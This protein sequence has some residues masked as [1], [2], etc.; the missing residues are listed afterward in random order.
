M[1]PK[2]IALVATMLLTSISALLLVGGVSAG[3]PTLQTSGPLPSPAEMVTFLTNQERASAG[4]PPLKA[5][6]LLDQAATSHSLAMAVA[7]FF[8]HINPF[9]GTDPGDR[10]LEAGY[11]FSGVAENIAEGPGTADEVVQGWMNSPGHRANILDPSYREIGTGYVFDGA[12]TVPCGD[13]PC[14]HYWTQ[15]FGVQADVYPLI[16]SGEAISTTT[17][18]VKIY[19]H[20]QEWATEMR[21]RNDQ[22]EFTA[23][24]PFVAQREW[25]LPTEPGFH[26]VTTEI[27]AG[28]RIA[29]AS[30]AI[31]YVAS[32]GAPQPEVPAPPPPTPTPQPGVPGALA[33]DAK[34]DPTPVVPGQE[35]IVTI[36]LR[37][38]DLPECAGIPGWP[39]DAILYVDNSASAGS[40]AGSKLEQAKS[41]ALVLVDQMA[42]PVYADSE[43]A[44]ALSRFGMVSAS[45]V[46][47]GVMT[48]ISE[49]SEDFP[50]A[51]TA[52]GSISSGADVA[53][54]E[55]IQL[56]I[57]EMQAKARPNGRQMMLTV[58][59]DDVPFTEDATQA[60]AQAQAAGIELYVIALGDKA[61]ISPN[62]EAE[63][64]AGHDHVYYNPTAEDIRRL[65]IGATGGSVAL[66]AKSIK[67]VADASSSN[68]VTIVSWGQ[69]GALEDGNPTWRL[70][71][72]G[73]GDTADLT[74]TIGIKPAAVTGAVSIATQMRY[75]DCS[76]YLRI[77][78]G[79]I[80]RTGIESPPVQPTDTPTPPPG[81]VPAPAPTRDLAALCP[82]SNSVDVVF[83]M[84]TSGS[85][86]DE[87]SEL[88]GQIDTIVSSLREMGIVVN[89]RIL[90]I[91][92][93]RDCTADTVANLVPGRVDN[94][95]DWGP[96]VADLAEGYPWKTGYTRLIV[97]MSD[98]GPE[99]GDSV[100]D[101][102]NDRRA[103]D[104][105]IAAAQANNTLVSP[106][107]GT[108]YNSA[109]E[110][111]ARDLAHSTNGE[112]F[113]S[114]DPPSD[115]ADGLARLLAEAACSP[116][117]DIV[118][119]ECPIA[120]D[121]VITIAGTNFMEGI[122]V[123]IAGQPARNVVRVNGTELQALIPAGLP[124]GRYDITVINPPGGW[125]YTKKEAIIVGPCD[126]PPPVP[127]EPP[128]A[129]A[130]FTVTP[131]PVTPTPEPLLA[132]PRSPLGCGTWYW[133][134]LPWL[135]P[136]LALLLWWLIM[137]PSWHRMRE[138]CEQKAWRCRIPCLLLFLYTLWLAYLIG[139]ALGAGLCVPDEAVYFWRQGGGL[140]SLGD[141]GIYVTS[142]DNEG[143][144]QPFTAANRHGCVGCHAVSSSGGMLASTGEPVPGPLRVTTLAGEDVPIPQIDALYVNWSP[145]GH[146]LAYASPEG[147]I[148]ILDLEAGTTVPLAGAS[149]HG[150]FETMPAWSHDG[151]RIAFVRTTSALYGLMIDAP[152]DIYTVPSEGGQAQPLAGASGGG[153]SYYPAF[154]PDGQWLAYT[155]HTTG[156]NSY[157]DPAAEIFVVPAGGGQSQ[158]IAANDAADGT[159]LANVSNS[160]PTWS[161][162]GS[163][164]AFSSKRN[165]ENY[166]IMLAAID[167]QGMSGPA[168]PLPGAAQPGVFEHVPFWGKPPQ[169]VPWWQRLLDLWPWLIPLLILGLL[170][171]LLCR[172]RVTVIVEPP[173]PPPP[174]P[175]RK[176]WAP[177]PPVGQWIGPPP[178]WNPEPT[179]VIG[180][181]GTGRWILTL[182]KKNLLDAGAGNITEDVRLLLLDTG[183]G[184]LMDGQ[185][186]PVSFAGV[187]LSPDETIVLGEDL[188]DLVRAIAEDEE[189]RVETEM[190]GWFPAKTYARRLSAAELDL[191]EGTHHRRPMG[192]AAI[193]RQARRGRNGELWQRLLESAAAVQEEDH[194]RIMI[195]GSLSGG[196][197][198]AAVFDAAYL[199]RHAGWTVGAKATTVEGFLA[200]QHTFDRVAT[201]RRGLAINT[202]AAMRDMMRFQLVQDRGYPMRY[203]RTEAGD[204]V[205]DGRVVSR[206]LDDCLLFDAQRPLRPLTMETP[207]DGVLASMADAITLHLDRA[208]RVGIDSVL[209]YRRTARQLTDGEQRR[210]AETV[211]SSLGTFA[212]RLPIYD[213]I[214]ALKARWAKHLLH[215]FL[216]GETGGEVRFDPALN[217]EDPAARMEEL[218][219][220]FLR[221]VAGLGTIPRVPRF[222]FSLL[223]EEGGWSAARAPELQA[224]T[225]GSADQE[226]RSYRS[227]LLEGVTKLLN[228]SAEVELLHAR[229]G[230]IGYVLH[231]L[232]RVERM[233][234][235]VEGEV[236]MLRAKVGEDLTPILA[237][238]DPLAESYRSATADLRRSLQAQAEALTD[239]AGGSIVETARG[240]DDDAEGAYEQL[241]A[242]EKELNRRREQMCAIKVRGYFLSGELLKEWYSKYLAQTVQ[243]HLERFYWRPAPDGRGVDL[244]FAGVGDQPVRLGGGGATG[245]AA[246]LLDLGDYLARPI[247]NAE[248]LADYL[249]EEELKA[250]QLPATAQKLWEW[251]SPL[252]DF[253]RSAAPETQSR[254]VLGANKTVQQAQ[255]LANEVARNLPSARQMLNLGLTDPYTLLLAQMVD[256]IPVGATVPYRDAESYY[257]AAH[258]LTPETVGRGMGAE[259]DAVF[260]AERHA[261]MYEQRVPELEQMPRLFHPLVV[262]GLE[263][264]RRAR[265][266]ALGYAAGFIR[267]EG[268]VQGDAF[269][270]RVP[271][272][273]AIPLTTPQDLQDNL[274]LPVSA[275]LNFTLKQLERTVDE[276]KGALEALPLEE[277]NARWQAFRERTL[278]QLSDKQGKRETQDLA[279]FIRLVLRDEERGRSEA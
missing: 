55:G 194:V 66:S 231:F 244:T 254:V 178:V 224:L 202:F 271:G 256:V 26:T 69:G 170:C 166:D 76:G 23:W 156:S 34:L 89:Y 250:D 225:V 222:L 117:I 198:G 157:S 209:A 233:W 63:L 252:L 179:L 187:E 176:A 169:L 168:V 149:Q 119:P 116:A 228:G 265:L 263:D 19:V 139:Q 115:L 59:H 207:V 109:I 237:G 274:A 90:G 272:R 39:L 86:D 77:E 6:P 155:H 262:A 235:D 159:P 229:S 72:I 184:E 111:L 153:F 131:M 92:A 71:E 52:V 164:L 234:K 132:L 36:T 125:D 260:P 183:E 78:A 45:T 28:E 65:F 121:T 128:A 167:A 108:G 123:Q 205:L 107:L 161:R 190:Q 238:L 29:T 162:D 68:D 261:L 88:C 138:R 201:N 165:D 91:A 217:R 160:W 188:S 10:V 127:T 152:C 41:L 135:L 277:R 148:G 27:R 221:G 53:L 15:K 240:A 47:T 94:T 200:T 112:I 98:E 106:V 241:A 258:G 113:E 270:L 126:L 82:N 73:K 133:K 83:A 189:Q 239:R 204:A 257:L 247:W 7:D 74:L 276:L 147:D 56:A 140:L 17:A 46:V 242:W 196:L 114:V 211:V 99:D 62:D 158:R 154:S 175:E 12:D 58:L 79:P 122:E 51:Q 219:Y 1:K 191:A 143:D 54:V 67:L 102:G 4:L 245:L 259:P 24:E 81:E 220:Q 120:E 38:Q 206:L 279:A 5:N 3:Q 80:I 100:H 95:E 213:L 32:P 192:R 197:G 48:T 21:L 43:S 226:E 264:D 182:L 8:D 14:Q 185:Q 199:A 104:T 60:A 35:A 212:Y 273:E 87:F 144:P 193:F 96:A 124:L 136:L 210:T 255:A 186:V 278:P 267:Q 141:Y 214:E 37:G 105:A 84:D 216:V 173:P 97:P 31:Y 118:E 227:Y 70:K 268:A 208:S 215:L 110:R 151:T 243:S 172:R 103:I 64:I 50:A 180:L 61:Q 11:G 25:L 22:Q 177:A 40:G 42:Q 130:E 44:P 174:P 145:D 249:S 195:V 223:R 134:L 18:T 101:P 16:I 230:K 248:T 163:W 232:Q 251:S 275:L 150:V 253:D 266:F 203:D 129:P 93:T 33:V 75:I 30:D 20:G 57:A 146:K 2:K 85:M 171:L 49:L 142:L 269:L 181:G 13:L 246:A 9:T 236:Q 137:G 218:V